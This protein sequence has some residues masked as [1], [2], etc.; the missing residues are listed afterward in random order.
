MWREFSKLSGEYRFKCAEPSCGKAFLTSYSLK[1]HVRVHTKVKP[2][3]CNHKGC[4]KAFNTLYRLRAHQRLHSGNTFNCEE[5]GCVKFFT[6]LSDLKKHI[7]THTQ[8]R[9]YK[10]REKGCG[11]AFTVSHHLKTHKRTHTGE[12]PYV[13]TFDNCKRCFT[14]P[15]SLKSHI[16][17]HN[18][19]VNETKQKDSGSDDTT[20]ERNKPPTQLELKLVKVNVSDTAIPSYAIVPISSDF[21]QNN[22]NMPYAGNVVASAPTDVALDIMDHRKLDAKLDYI[23]T[24]DIEDSN[25]TTEEVTLLAPDISSHFLADFNEHAVDAFN[26]NDNY[27]EFK[28]F[29]EITESNA[30]HDNLADIAG[31][32]NH[33]HES[34][35]LSETRG[36]SIDRKNRLIPLN[37]E[38]KIMQDG[39]QNAIAHISEGKD[40]ASDIKQFKNK[41]TAAPNNVFDVDRTNAGS[42]TD[43]GNA[44]YSANCITSH[45]PDIISSSNETNLFDSGIE[46]LSF[47]NDAT[48]QNESLDA[49][50]HDLCTDVITNTHSEAVELA[51]AT[52]EELPSPWIDVMALAT[53][54][55]LRTQSWSELNAFPTAVHSLVDLVGP[56]PY[57][58]EIEAQLSSTENL[59]NIDAVNIEHI[60]ANTEVVQCQEAAD[61]EQRTDDVRS[62]KDRNVLQEITADADI[63]KCVDCKCD[64][65][66]NC[67]NCTN[68]PATTAEVTKKDTTLK[69]VEDFVSSLQNGC[70]CNADSGGCGSC[71]VVICLKTLQQLQKV[72]SRNCCKSTSSATCCREKLLPSL[73]KC[74][75][76]RN[77]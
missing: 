51:I 44:L 26:N 2:F 37:L 53:A 76:A 55:A 19:T 62:K 56:E 40:F 28:V 1:I 13:C 41:S 54:P 21:A 69:I 70:S 50:S 6:T 7:R 48:L 43:D 67:Q 15:H 49:V 8:E 17:T 47:I 30:Q 4:K 65:L 63:C 20:E 24:K 68:S 25:R 57:P 12:R 3:E 29:N 66:Q 58:L 10:C 75:L 5:T 77:Q 32:Q 33:P 22:E 71:C 45:I 52:E 38:Q 9:P 64:S 59:K 36:D 61:Y 73:M 60:S 42:I 74:K 11:K 23:S 16:K 31:H 14:T 46:A 72:F 18:K 27:N 39:L 34:T 35:S